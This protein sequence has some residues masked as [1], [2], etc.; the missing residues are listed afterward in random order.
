MGSVESTIKLEIDKGLAWQLANYLKATIDSQK[1]G[2]GECNPNWVA[3]LNAL[4]KQNPDLG[5]CFDRVWSAKGDI[6]KEEALTEAAELGFVK[7]K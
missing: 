4:K 2:Y 5:R 7:R 6:E 1:R 3:V